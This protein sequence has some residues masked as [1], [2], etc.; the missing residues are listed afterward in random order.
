MEKQRFQ[1]GISGYR[2]APESFHVSKG[3]P[4]QKKKAVPLTPE[5]R[6]EVG[7]G[8]SPK[9]SGLL[10]AMSN[11]LSESGRTKASSM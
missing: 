6:Q 5:E 7:Y 8:L 4:G 3:L 10:W 2:W 9:A 11:T 1:Y